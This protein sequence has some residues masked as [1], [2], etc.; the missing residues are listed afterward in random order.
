[1]FI[2]III[3]DFCFKSQ[4]CI[5]FIFQGVLSTEFLANTMDLNGTIFGS[6]TVYGQPS[7][8]VN[9]TVN[10][11]ELTEVTDWTYDAATQVLN[12]IMFAPV[13][14]PLSVIIV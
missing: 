11:D 8:P 9:I 14:I 3:Y 13:E 10:D 4:C 7:A 5:I 6:V 12:I 2:T 1:M